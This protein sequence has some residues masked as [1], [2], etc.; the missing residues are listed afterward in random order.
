MAQRTIYDEGHIKPVNKERKILAA[1]I[2]VYH[3]DDKE[4]FL[5]ITFEEYHHHLEQRIEC[6]RELT[7]SISQARC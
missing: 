4:Y 7:I 5:F 3:R 1:R 2:V 6:R